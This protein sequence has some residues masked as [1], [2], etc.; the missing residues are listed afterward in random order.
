LK[1]EREANK[2]VK[3]Q[4]IG[5]KKK[6]QKSMLPP[7]FCSRHKGEISE[8]RRIDKTSHAREIALFFSLSPPRDIK[9]M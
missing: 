1:R 2:N 5:K 6:T 8:Q 7:V 4:K 9:I 3:N